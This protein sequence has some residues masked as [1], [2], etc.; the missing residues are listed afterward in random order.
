MHFFDT[1]DAF[2]IHKLFCF[3]TE[4]LFVLFS[5][6]L[7]LSITIPLSRVLWSSLIK[8]AWCWLIDLHGTGDF[9]GL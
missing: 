2:V 5:V 7:G 4:W 3:L 6:F 8:T 1:S 9:D